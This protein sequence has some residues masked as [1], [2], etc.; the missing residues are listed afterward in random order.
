MPQTNETPQRSTA[1]LQNKS[2]PEGIGDFENAPKADLAQAEF[3]AS[4]TCR[5]LRAAAL[6]ECLRY[7]ALRIITTA[8]TASAHLADGDD[9]GAL[10]AFRRLWKSVKTD[11]AIPVAELA[12]LGG[13]Q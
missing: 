3:A 9:E 6:R 12:R 5:S 8:T 10:A 13:G 7:E 1:R 2:F 11:I 4:I